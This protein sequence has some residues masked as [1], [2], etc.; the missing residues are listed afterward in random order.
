MASTNS[1]AFGSLKRASL[2]SQWRS[3]ASAVSAASA[4]TATTNGDSPQRSEGWPMTA[5]SRTPGWESTAFSISA[6]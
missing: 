1:T 3:T 5:H 4:L 2:P 6:G